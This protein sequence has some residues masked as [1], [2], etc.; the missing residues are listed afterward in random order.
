MYPLGLEEL[1]WG[2]TKENVW[3]PLRLARKMM[4]WDSILLTNGHEPLLP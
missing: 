1:R 3:L 2:R 4:R